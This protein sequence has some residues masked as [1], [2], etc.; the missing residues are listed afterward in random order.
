MLVDRMFVRMPGGLVH[1]RHA[2]GDGSARPLLLLHASPGSSRGLEPLVAALASRPG[3]GRVIAPDMPGNGDSADLAPE[4]PD[5]RWYADA[6]DALAGE[7]GLGTIDVYGSHTG[8]R[9]ACELAAAHPGRV[10]R[11]VFDGI[12]EYSDEMKELLL[13]EYAPAMQ[14]DDYGRQ[15]MWAFNFVRDQALHFPHFLRDPEHRL[16]TRAVPEAA[17][18]HGSVME[19]L[20][21]LTSYHKAYR[22]AFAYRSASRLR[23]VAAPCLLMKAAD[24]LPWLNAS[25]D[26]LAAAMADVRVVPVPGDVTAKAAMMAGFLGW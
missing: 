16:M 14:P 9:L 4:A 24:D 18:L 7:M 3:A 6:V 21:G 23:E 5:M 19:V 22:A 8:A 1:M 20:K 17:A 12:G 15:F 26:E 10:G 13:R 25:G 2:T 11:V